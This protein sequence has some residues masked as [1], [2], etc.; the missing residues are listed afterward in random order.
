MRMACGLTSSAYLFLASLLGGNFHRRAI[1][2]LED[3][4]AHLRV[5]DFTPAA[6]GEDAVMSGTLDF[7]VLLVRLG[8][9]EAQVV[10]GFGLAR[11]RDVVQLAFDGEV[12][13]GLD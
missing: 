10:R 2:E 11:A 8:D 1:V 6:A 12:G 13:G 5:H 4:V 7:Q 9:V 3:E